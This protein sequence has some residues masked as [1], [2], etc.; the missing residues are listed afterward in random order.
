[1]AK[2]AMKILRGT[3]WPSSNKYTIANR[4]IPNN[5][6]KCLLSAL[7]PALTQET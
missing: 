7:N 2:I 4:K 3:F 1:M 5:F 6:N